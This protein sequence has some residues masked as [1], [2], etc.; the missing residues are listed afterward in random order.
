M[1][2]LTQNL[3]VCAQVYHVM[4]FHT[5]NACWHACM[6][7]YGNLSLSTIEYILQEYQWEKKQK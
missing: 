4:V 6:H 2:R 3:I 5:L 7:I 1:H